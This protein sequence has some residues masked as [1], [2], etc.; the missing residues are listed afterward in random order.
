MEGLFERRWILSRQ[1]KELQM[2]HSFIYG[3]ESWTLERCCF[4]S[5]LLGTT[6]TWVFL[7]FYLFLGAFVTPLCPSIPP[8]A[9][10]CFCPSTDPR[11]ANFQN[12][13]IL[14]SFPVHHQGLVCDPQLSSASAKRWETFICISSSFH[15]PI[16]K[17]HLFYCPS[18]SG[19]PSPIPAADSVQMRSLPQRKYTFM[20]WLLIHA[21]PQSLSRD[22]T[23]DVITVPSSQVGNIQCIL[24]RSPA[25]TSFPSA[26]LSCFF[27]RPSVIGRGCV[28]WIWEV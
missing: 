9:L 17:F 23:A 11:A 24:E 12:S 27:T 13:F 15:P 7:L 3:S 4:Y 18:R 22:A 8:P 14:V 19:T 20:C 25:L 10:T 1:Q 26:L 6:H 28:I 16:H 5:G 21:A 2:W